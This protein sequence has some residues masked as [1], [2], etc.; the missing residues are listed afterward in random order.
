[1]VVDGMV[2]TSIG[3]ESRSINND[4]VGRAALEACSTR[5]EISLDG[6]EIAI[7]ASSAARDDGGVDIAVG[8]DTLETLVDA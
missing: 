3:K 5:R 7:L 2:R 8:E 4:V 1:M 6:G